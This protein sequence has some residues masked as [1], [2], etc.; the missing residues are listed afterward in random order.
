MEIVPGPDFPT[1]GSSSAAGCRSPITTGR[2]SIMVRSR[3]KT[4]EGRRPPLD[5]AHRNPLPAG[6]NALVEKIAEAAKDKRIEGVA[7]SATN[8]T[9]KACASSST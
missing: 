6:K 9:A 4:E 5:R 8:R 2:G 1:G 7:T 3:H